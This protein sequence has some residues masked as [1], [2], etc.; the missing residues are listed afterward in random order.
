MQKNTPLRYT[1]LLVIV[2]GQLFANA[3]WAQSGDNPIIAL[4]EM[5]IIV[6]SSGSMRWGAYS[7][8]GALPTCA[9]RTCCGDPTYLCECVGKGKVCNSWNGSVCYYCSNWSS[10]TTTY[11]SRYE[12]IREVL[13]GTYSS[14]NIGTCTNQQTNGLLD[15]YKDQIRFRHLGKS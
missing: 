8:T 1:A 13:T 4:P 11:R 10:T 5:M 12:M 3:A 7:G 2:F 9:T 15:L 14:S 6:D